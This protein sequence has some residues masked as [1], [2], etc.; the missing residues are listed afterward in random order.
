M[1]DLI[2]IQK[3]GS[4]TALKYG[5]IFFIS[6]AFISTILL[7]SLVLFGDLLAM[8]SVLFLVICYISFLVL[9]TIPFIISLRY[10]GK[11]LAIDLYNKKSLIKA[12]AR[13]SFSI[14]IVLWTL[15][16]IAVLFFSMGGAFIFA[17]VSY[18]LLILILS[19]LTTFT[20]G[21]IIAKESQSKI[22]KL[23][24]SETENVVLNQNKISNE[25]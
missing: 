1:I 10:F 23:P 11:K 15:V 7:L 13:F 18:I 20:I 5:I 25:R 22:K 24:S 9:I 4:K 19:T 8:F 2:Q 17:L 12:S 21:L 16:L 14:N 6:I 3:I